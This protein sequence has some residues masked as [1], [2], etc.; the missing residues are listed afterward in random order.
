MMERKE[1]KDA[2]ILL[3]CQE[4]G[5]LLALIGKGGDKCHIRDPTGFGARYG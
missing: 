1:E 4:K 3:G 2:T 5:V